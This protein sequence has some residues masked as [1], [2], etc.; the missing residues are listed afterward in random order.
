MRWDTHIA[1]GL[2]VGGFVAMAAPLEMKLPVLV[3]AAVAALLPDLDHA[4]SKLSRAIRR[5]PLLWPLLPICWLARVGGHRGPTHSLALCTLFSL[6]VAGWCA[7]QA[8]VAGAAS[9]QTTVW[10]A[11]ALVL[12]Y[13]SHV[14]LDALTPKGIPL[15]WPV[16]RTMVRIETGI[17]TG[18][19]GETGVLAGLLIIDAVLILPQL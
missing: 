14:A 3:T 12:G 6:A 1:G 10:L 19:F 17:V 18:S 2:A 15:W 13:I 16:D 8:A 5:N 7:V 9:V 11:I 4:G